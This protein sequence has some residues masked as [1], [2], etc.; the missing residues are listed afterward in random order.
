MRLE[1]F[2]WQNIGRQLN[3]PRQARLIVR[4][5]VPVYNPL[6][7]EAAYISYELSESSKYRIRDSSLKAM[8]SLHIQHIVLSYNIYRLAPVPAN[9]GIE[10]MDSIEFSFLKSLFHKIG[11]KRS[12]IY[13]YT[14]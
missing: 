13:F 5:L 1:V 8:Y 9:A 12:F 6:V 3:I 7:P 4:I 14:S 11:D 2:R 10:L